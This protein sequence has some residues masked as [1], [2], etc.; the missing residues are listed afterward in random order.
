MP[1]LNEIDLSFFLKH[2]EICILTLEGLIFLFPKVGQIYPKMPF[3]KKQEINL[4]NFQYIGFQN[5]RKHKTYDAKNKTVGFFID[6]YRFKR[7]A[8]YPWKFINRLKQ[9]KNVM[10]PDFSCYLDMSLTKQWYNTYLNR[11]IGSYWQNCG[12]TVIPTISW[13]DKESFSFCFEGIESGSIVAVST[14]GTKKMAKEL[15]M[16]GFQKLCQVIKPKKV[17]CYCNPYP[18]MYKYTD[19]IVVEH[20]AQSARKRAYL[21]EMSKY[22][23]SL[24]DLLDK[25]TGGII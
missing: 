7:V 23:Y 24:P 25:L 20:E 21:K 1:L 4:N 12:L 19:I 16:A 13:S 15:F 14:I 9:Y 10:S 2:P 3:I 22:Y 17:I 6:D 8:F 5:T 18:E 11:L